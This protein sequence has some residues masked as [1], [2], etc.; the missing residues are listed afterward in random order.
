M[1]EYE[2]HLYMILFP[3]N[4]LVA[5]Q[6]DADKFGK[7]YTTGSAKHI[8]GKVIFAEVDINFR[9]DH[10]KID[11][12]LE[13]TVPH[14]NGDPK[15][16]KFIKSYNVLEHIDL[17]AIQKLFLCTRNGAVLPLEAKEFTYQGEPGRIRVYQ[18]ITPLD[19]LVATNKTVREF[20][21]FITTKTQSKGAPKIFFTEIDFDIDHFMSSNRNKDIYHIA[22]PGVNPYRFFDCVV[23]LQEHPEKLTKTIGLGNILREVSYKYL[24]HGFWFAK[25]EEL[26]FFP[27]PSIADLEDKYFYWWK[28]VR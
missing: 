2:K 28:Y 3:I 16:T 22:L 4:A 24:K 9:N 23:E 19:T 1:P 20:G 17:T 10:F 7:H 12:Y 6:L 27:M 18:E 5:S 11:E 21:D 26:R 14:E 15:K 25:G 8:T 13:K